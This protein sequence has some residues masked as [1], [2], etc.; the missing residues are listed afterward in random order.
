MKVSITY[1]IIYFYFIE[2]DE[3]LDFINKLKMEL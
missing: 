3:T 1:L 2:I